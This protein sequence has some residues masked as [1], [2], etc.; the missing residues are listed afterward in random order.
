M[1]SYDLATW[2]IVRDYGYVVSN[3]DVQVACPYVQIS[4][5]NMVEYIYNGRVLP[6]FLAFCNEAEVHHMC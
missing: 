5:V 4:A 3:T 1:Y 6:N 2:V